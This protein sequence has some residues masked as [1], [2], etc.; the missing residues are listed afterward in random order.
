MCPGVPGWTLNSRVYPTILEYTLRCW[1][2]SWGSGMLSLFLVCTWGSRRCLRVLKCVTWDY[3]VFLFSGGL[4]CAILS[5]KPAAGWV[6]YLRNLCILKITW[7][8]CLIMSIG[9]NYKNPSSLDFKQLSFLLGWKDVRACRG[10]FKAFLAI[11]SNKTL[12]SLR[13]VF[14]VLKQEI[15]PMLLFLKH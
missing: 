3:R 2:V 15:N 12:L 8:W 13:L 1:G 11:T 6:G 7:N 14:P 10:R 9:H 5:N 4:G